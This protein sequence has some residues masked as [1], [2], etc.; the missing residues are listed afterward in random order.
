MQS[1][2]DLGFNHHWHTGR[3]IVELY[4]TFHGG[5]NDLFTCEDYFLQPA[6]Y[7]LVLWVYLCSSLAESSNNKFYGY[8]ILAANAYYDWVVMAKSDT[9]R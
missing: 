9:S 4:Y 7:N 3:G 6:F 2:S 5:N 8:S 1:K